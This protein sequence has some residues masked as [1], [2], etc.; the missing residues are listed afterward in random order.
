MRTLLPDPPPAEFEELLERRRLWGADVYDEVWEGVLHMNPMAH[1][2]HA[3]I[4]AQLLALLTPI[5]RVAGLT[6]LG[7]FNLGEPDD[8]RIPDGGLQRAGSG[9]LYYVTAALVI[10]IVS[11]GDET[12]N[13][14]AF[15]AAHEVDELL[16]VDPEAR[17][18]TW[19][20]RR[21]DRYAPI[22]RSSLI[23]LG[24]E[25]LSDRLDWPAGDPPT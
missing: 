13:K 20:A 22:G 5:G 10:E 4:Q 12:W 8:Y 16:I 18:V 7:N 21:D 6:A 14:L 3:M 23:A 2:R 9:E 1:G 17:T 24:P 25:E 15:Y 11:P 19:L